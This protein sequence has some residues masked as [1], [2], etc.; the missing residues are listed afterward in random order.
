[1]Y[2]KWQVPIIQGGMGVGISMGSLAGAVA[3]EGG[4]GVIS[5]AV[6]GFREP[7]AWTNPLE[8]GIR[9]L[10][11]EI[12]KAREISRG[13]G[14][15]AINAMVVTTDYRAMVDAAIEEGVDAVISGA[16][17]PL[18]LPEIAGERSVMLAPIVSSTRAAKLIAR[19]WAR[20]NRRPDFIVVEGPDAGG[21]LGFSSE[22]LHQ[23]SAES[24]EEIVSS[25]VSEHSA[26]PVFAA[27]SVFD[28]EDIRRMR[29]LG[30]EGVQ[31]ATRFI[32][33]EEC[34][35]SQE[36]KDAI[37]HAT[38]EDLR[39]IESPVGLPG[40]AIDSPLLQRVRERRRSVPTRCRNCIKTCN[41]K[42]TK[43]CI[44]NALIKAFYGDWENGLFFAGANVGR[45]RAMTTV[46]EL[47]LELKQGFQ[48]L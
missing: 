20:K 48:A 1:M 21:H 39:I 22:E 29:K 10:Q 38:Q 3:R 31:I 8:A 45:V 7:D 4:M 28:A 44:S 6:I 23:C 13:N 9:A 24:L 25:V 26:T 5:T 41:P 47:M 27:G 18:E 42:E 15:I 37:L 11:G 36:Y 14:A 43:Y 19:S 30:A 12:R 2:K 46:R 17:L 34:D 16:G 40:R 32:A 35:A 33:T